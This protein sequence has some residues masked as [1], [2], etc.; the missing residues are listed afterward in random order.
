MAVLVFTRYSNLSTTLPEHMDQNAETARRQHEEGKQ[1]PYP[2]GWGYSVRK[3]HD[4]W[5]LTKKGG[6]WHH[7]HAA[8]SDQGFILYL[9]KCVR[10]DVSI[11]VN[12]RWGIKPEKESDE[13]GVLAKYQLDILSCIG[14][15]VIKQGFD[16][17]PHDTKL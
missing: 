16:L 14:L 3:N 17:V 8:H 10:Q 1:H 11:V 15:L 5:E 9:A 2:Q 13:A 7:F 6:G 4:A 12:Q